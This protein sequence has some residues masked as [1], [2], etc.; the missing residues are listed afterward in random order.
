MVDAD[1]FIIRKVKDTWFVWHPAIST[2][3]DFDS[4]EECRMFVVFGLSRQRRNR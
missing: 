3:S 4:F 2:W 1:K